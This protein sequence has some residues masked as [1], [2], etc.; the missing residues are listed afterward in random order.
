MR[1]ALYEQD[2]AYIQAVGFGGLVNG[3]MPA[4][5]ERLRSCRIPVRRVI[6]VGCGAGISTR[7]L[8]DAGF[9]TW[10]IEPS[11][12]LRAV[13]RDNSPGTRFVLG[14][15]YEVA[16]EPC[17]AILAL[18]E[19]LTY[20]APAVDADALVRDFFDGAA[21]ALAPGGLLVFDLIDCAGAPLDARGWSSGDDWA[22]LYET[23]EDQPAR[24]L[25]RHI[26]TFRTTGA[27]GSTY[28]RS[29]EVHHVRT[30]AAAEVERWLDRAGFG[31]EVSDAYGSYKLA[32]R[33]RAFF[34]VR[35]HR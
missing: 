25:T 28:R 20:H 10:A 12:S 6:D 27:D 21:R 35:R 24:S 22:L 1:M 17:E 19:P 4:V 26:E 14:S 8:V 34:A 7:A 16:L 15:A 9:E 13:A 30:F 18:G 32:S 5:I 31:V 11:P 3:A 2:L 23:R 29:R 33:R